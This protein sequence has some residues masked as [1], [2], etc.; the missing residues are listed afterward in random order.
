MQN[1]NKKIGYY[2]SLNTELSS[3]EEQLPA[4]IIQIDPSKPL[5]ASEWEQLL[6]KTIPA[7][8]PEHE[9]F[10]DSSI[11]VSWEHSYTKTSLKEPSDPRFTGTD[12]VYLNQAELEIFQSYNKPAALAASNS[13]QRSS[14][15]S[16]YDAPWAGF[17]LVPNRP[18]W[19]PITWKQTE[20]TD[21]LWTGITSVYKLIPM[22]PS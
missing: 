9:D 13:D 16:P 18:K 17:L 7:Q 8:S 11:R 21:A 2:S 19:V 1:M 20:F 6:G 14:N 10:T 12:S 4:G 15:G 5:P 3:D 22:V